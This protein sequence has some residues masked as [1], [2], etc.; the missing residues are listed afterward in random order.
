MFII[1]FFLFDKISI[2]YLKNE[3]T[4]DELESVFPNY[5]TNDTKVGCCLHLMNILEKCLKNRLSFYLTYISN[6]GM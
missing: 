4:Y 5:E 3:N 2:N 6:N 1:G